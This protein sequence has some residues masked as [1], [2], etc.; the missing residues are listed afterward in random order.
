M[1]AGQIEKIQIMLQAFTKGFSKNLGRA[2]TQLKRA[3]KNMNEFGQVMKMPM[4]GFKEMNKGAKQMTTT[5]GKFANNMRMMTHGMRGFRMEMLGVMF[6]GM[7]LQRTFLGLLNPVME[8]FGVMDL[9][10]VMLLTLFLPIMQALFPYMLAMMQWFMDLSDPVKK[11]L[12]AFVLLGVIFGTLLMMLGMWALGIGSLIQIIPNLLKV[13]SLIGPFLTP[14]IAIV[15]GLIDVFIGW[16]KSTA[17][18]IGG[19]LKVIAGVAG[20]IAVVMGAPALL[21]AAIVVAV[22]GIITAVV[23]YW[24]SIK[25]A[26]KDGWAWVKNISRGAF[27]WLK[28]KFIKAKDWMKGLFS[29]GDDDNS[30]SSGSIPHKDDFIWRPGQGAVSINPNDTLVGFKGAAPNLGG[31]GASNITNNFYGFTMDE[32]KR[33]LDD[34]DRKVTENIRRIVKT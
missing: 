25:Q 14:I 5:G 12:G 7:M 20:I 22:V 26:F 1:A 21:V 4:E 28:N 16:G 27:D 34:R 30:R 29:F 10:R 11:V 18:V 31:G 6:F 32:L 24:D 17:K 3:G 15:W 9:F 33:E 2:Q 19:I 8:A 13:F 23:R